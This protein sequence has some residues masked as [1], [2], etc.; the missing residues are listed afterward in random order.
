[1]E[2]F[3]FAEYADIHLI[4]G[5]AQGNAAQ[6]VRLY[7][8]RF[9]NRRLPHWKT[10]VKVDTR[11]RE[12]GKHVMMSLSSNR[13]FIF[14]LG[15]FQPKR[16]GVGRPRSA[17]TVETEEHVLQ[18]VDEDP[19]TSVRKLSTACNTSKTTVRTI[20]RNQLLH[21]YHIQKVHTLLAADYPPRLEFARFF[22]EKQRRNPN[23]ISEVLFT[24]EAGFTRDGII[25][26]H[27]LHIWNDENPHAVVQTKHQE[28]FIINVW[29]GL[30]GNYLVGPY[31]IDG[32]LNGQKYLEFLQEHLNPL[33][34]EV[35]LDTRNNMW[36]MHDGAPPHFSRNVRNYLNNTFRDKWIGRSGPVSWPARS[37]DLTPMDFY[38]WGHMKA[39][40]YNT[41][42]NSTEELLNRIRTYSDYIRNDHE[43]L[44]RVQQR[45][46]ANFRKCVEVEGG[47]IENLP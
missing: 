15:S 2:E 6:A 18:L 41:T 19:Y 31:I 8:E 7:A 35:P 29:M 36:L 1:M 3:S 32:T 47:H 14:C 42:I 26:C 45:C 33:L 44:F 4:Y 22:L 9:P 34:E 46:L 12:T 23:F 10:F 17:R 16:G 11:L 43:T 24:D 40:V 38:V 21:P 28:R 27:N 13:S 20:L 37:P 5:L 30:V 39:L 25:N